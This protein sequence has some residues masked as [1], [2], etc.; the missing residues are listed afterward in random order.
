LRRGTDVLDWMKSGIGKE[1]EIEVVVVAEVEDEAEEEVG[2][3][4]LALPDEETTVG[5][6]GA[7]LTTGA[8]RDLLAVRPLPGGAIAPHL[9]VLDPHRESSV[10]RAPDLAPNQAQ[11]HLHSA[12]RARALLL[13]VLD[14]QMTLLPTAAVVVAAVEPLRRPQDAQRRVQSHTVALPQHPVLMQVQVVR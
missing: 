12:A 7:D 10:P 14:L 13:V 6:A 9:V 4:T 2:S 1:V 11:D 3:M 5:E 8:P